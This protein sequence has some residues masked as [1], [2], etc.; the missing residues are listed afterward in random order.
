MWF[1]FQIITTYLFL[2]F[3]WDPIAY[4]IVIV[5][6][7]SCVIS[8]FLNFKNKSLQSPR[9]EHIIYWFVNM[10]HSL[11]VCDEHHL[12]PSAYNVYPVKMLIFSYMFNVNWSTHTPSHTAPHTH[13]W[14]MNYA[15]N[16]PLM[17]FLHR[18]V[19]FFYTLITCKIM[20]AYNYLI[21]PVCP[22][23]RLVCIR[24]RWTNG[25]RI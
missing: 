11:S 16:H 1:M 25:L 3:T 18:A 9:F 12:R 4:I 8:Q 22:K 19:P 10:S 23:R 7:L 24:C 21:W 14:K 15:K 2:E 17:V 6:R 20:S 5:V 13:I